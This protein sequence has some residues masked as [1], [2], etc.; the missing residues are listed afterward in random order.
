MGQTFMTQGQGRAQVSLE[1]VF[2][3]NTSPFARGIPTAKICLKTGKFVK[4]Y[5]YIKKKIKNMHFVSKRP[6]KA[7]VSCVTKN[8][9]QLYLWSVENRTA[10]HVYEQRTQHW[11]VPACLT[12]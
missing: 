11:L 6:A 2:L 1:R 3:K 7:S 5:I 8:Q 10:T 12:F 9:L 4:K